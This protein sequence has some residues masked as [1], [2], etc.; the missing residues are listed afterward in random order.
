MY[1]L[2]VSDVDDT[3]LDHNKQFGKNFDLFLQTLQNH[4]IYFTIAT[5]RS[6]QAIQPIIDQLQLKLPYATSN[7]AAI[8]Q[9]G[10]VIESFTIK[11]EPLKE[12]ITQAHEM[13]ITV[14]YAINGQ[15]YALSESP[16][17]LKERKQ[18]FTHQII[19]PLTEQ[20]WKTLEVD[21][22]LLVDDDPTTGLER[23]LN[24]SQ[25]LEEEYDYLTFSDWAM[26]IIGK[27]VNKGRALAWI[28]DYL[29]VPMEATIA[30]GDN[31]NDIALLRAAGKGI[32]VQNALSEAKA[33][34]DI[35]AK[36]KYCD[37]VIEE[38]QKLIKNK[39]SATIF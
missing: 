8:M 9:E 13:G 26:D 20:D 31:H 29:N 24:L 2:F 38:V 1:K 12:I 14:I 18:N 34:A 4:N 5:G 35:I 21:K 39:T 17:I 25:Q 10:K 7:G 28:A 19:Q 33:V 6:G 11:I 30:A 22:I 32:A 23:L 3:L 15:E 37:G 27:N 36:Q 16:F